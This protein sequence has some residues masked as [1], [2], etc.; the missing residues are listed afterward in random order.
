MNEIRHA[1]QLV[2]VDLGK[3][4]DQAFFFGSIKQDRVVLGTRPLL[5]DETMLY[6]VPHYIACHLRGDIE[7]LRDFIVRARPGSLSPEQEKGLQ[8]WN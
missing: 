2:P 7:R 8:L 5:A 3:V 1:Y 6:E 4:S